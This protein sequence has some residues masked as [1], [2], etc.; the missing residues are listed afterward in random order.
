MGHKNT[1]IFPL[2]VADRDSSWM[3]LLIFFHPVRYE[4]NPDKDSSSCANVQEEATVGSGK[5]HAVRR[6]RLDAEWT[7]RGLGEPQQASGDI[8]KG[9]PHSLLAT[10][11]GTF[12]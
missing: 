4:K 6:V 12:L 7:V 2:N 11:I 5:S 10:I 9:Y 8:R 3:N 1:I